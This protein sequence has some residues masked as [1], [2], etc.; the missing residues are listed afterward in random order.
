MT[1]TYMIRGGEEGRR[2]LDLL[3]Q[4]MGPTTDA[5]LSRS[6]IGG[7]TCVDVG[8]GTDVP[9]RERTTDQ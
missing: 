6:G 7:M 4:V 9:G 2:R 3:A 5:L 1:T 8:F